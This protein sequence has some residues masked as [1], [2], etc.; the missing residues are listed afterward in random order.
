[1]W[2]RYLAKYVLDGLLE[3]AV[4]KAVFAY[5]DAV[6]HAMEPSFEFKDEGARLNA[7]VDFHIMF[8]S[9]APGCPPPPIR[10]LKFFTS[11]KTQNS[12][13]D[14]LDRIDQSAQNKSR[15]SIK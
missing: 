2:F 6:N 4:Q 12:D 11:R 1:M 8:Y 10:K 13:V 7:E 5:V 3:P 9:F 15:V 14:V